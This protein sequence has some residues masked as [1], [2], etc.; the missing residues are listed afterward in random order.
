M[1][2]RKAAPAAPPAV[3]SRNEITGG[4]FF[5]AVI[6]GRNITVQLPPQIPTALG[7]LPLRTR[8]FTGRDADLGRLLGVLDPGGPEAGFV[9]VVAVAGLAGVGKTELV[10]QVAEE[11]R[12]RGWFPGGVL[13]VDVYGYDQQRRLEPGRALDGMLRSLGVAPE[14]IPLE[15]QDRAR[16]Y[17]SALAAFAD[18]GKDILVIIDNVS[19]TAQARPLL[20][21]GVGAR[22]LVTSRNSLGGLGARLLDLD[23]LDTD[24]AADLLTQ[25]LHLARGSADTRVR[26]HPAEVRAIAELCAGLPLAVEIVAALLATDPALSLHAM[27]TNLANAGGRLDELS[28]QDKAVRAAFDLSY[29]ELD[30]EESRL[31]R[32]MTL[33]PGAEV[34]TAAAATLAQREERVTRRLLGALA[35]AHLIEHGSAEARWRMHDLVRLYAQEQARMLAEQDDRITAL[36][37]LLQHYL[38]AAD[39]ADAHLRALPGTKVPERFT[40]REDALAWLDTEHEN[41]VSAVGAAAVDRPA[42]AVLLAAALAEFLDW[43]RRFDEWIDVSRTAVAAARRLGDK[44]GEGRALTNLGIAQWKTRQFQE[45]IDTYE[46]A[47]AIARETGDV[48][49]EGRALTNLGIALWELRRFDE[50]INPHQQAVAAF[51]QTGDLDREGRASSNLGLALQ[52]VGRFEEAI[53]A[54]QRAVDIYQQ[55]GKSQGEGMALVNLALALEEA[56]RLEEA[57]VAEQRGVAIFRQTGDRYGEGSALNNLGT[58]LRLVGR[59]EEAMQAHEQALAIA[60]EIGDQ[61]REGS[62]LNNLGTDLRLA[63]RTEEAMQAHQQALAIARLI[64]DRLSEAMALNN[65]GLAF[66]ALGRFDEAIKAHQEDVMI[67][68]GLGNPKRERQA[69]ENLNAAEAGQ[70]SLAA[71]RPHRWSL[72]RTRK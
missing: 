48:H 24:A 35:R 62:A 46:Q 49:G 11:A 66:Q 63:G 52:D 54:Q 32:L 26:E 57:I 29:R 7:G 60:R 8:T 28:Y 56:D 34:S 47:L 51:R 61:D 72:R 39:A 44:H 65:L 71:Q 4:V 21:S 50:A 15:V 25:Q 16:L 37:M 42:T 55:L 67:S 33:N 36:H 22:A 10:L 27:A 53:K 70:Q 20:P 64:G 45:A 41:L 68:R 40:G 3:T 12:K 14:Y 58:D 18:Q 17:S 9:Q 69:L 2:R 6:Q 31:F 59:T 1:L 30:D 38:A 23:V 19:S 13:F 5:N 43:R